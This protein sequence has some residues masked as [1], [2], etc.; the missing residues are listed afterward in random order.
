MTVSASLNHGGN[1][2]CGGGCVGGERLF[3]D[4]GAVAQYVTT[5]E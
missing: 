2:S 4:F 1:T 5:T 3:K